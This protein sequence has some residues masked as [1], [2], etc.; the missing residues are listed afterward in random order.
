MRIENKRDVECLKNENECFNGVKK[1]KFLKV[2]LEVVKWYF[3]KTLMFPL[4]FLR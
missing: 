4:M 1:N 3:K 2:V